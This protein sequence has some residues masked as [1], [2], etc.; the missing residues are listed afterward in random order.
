MSIDN[1]CSAAWLHHLGSDGELWANEAE[2]PPYL[3]DYAGEE[4]IR[5]IDDTGATSTALPVA[6]ADGVQLTPVGHFN[7]ASGAKVP[8]Y[9]RVEIPIR[10]EQGYLHP[11][12]GSV[13]EVVK[14]LGSG[15]E[16]ARF[17]D[18]YIWDTGGV[19]L[20]RDGPVGRGLE[21]EYNRLVSVYGTKGH[22][23]LHK[24]GNLYH[25]YVKKIGE[26]RRIG[27]LSPV[28]SNAPSPGFARQVRP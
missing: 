14:P 7:V 11:L 24:E 12:H 4:W 10:D 20:P 16:L 21:R 27:E 26:A 28:T 23:A 3:A 15:N 13:T 19:V 1:E 18:S 9:G 8:N 2:R 17:H 5:F 6:L 25:Y 22:I